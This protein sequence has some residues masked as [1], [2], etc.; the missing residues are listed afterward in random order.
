[1]LIRFR[2]IW[3]LAL[4]GVSALSLQTL[5]PQPDLA[6]EGEIPSIVYLDDLINNSGFFIRDVTVGS[7]DGDFE[8]EVEKGT[9]AFDSTGG[10]L[11]YLAIVEAQ[12]LYLPPPPKGTVIRAYDLAPKGAVFMPP[13]TLTMQY[14][15]GRDPGIG[16]YIA[17]WNGNRWVELGSAVN[18]DN[19]T[20]TAKV[21]HF[22]RFAII[23][24]TAAPTESVLPTTEL[25]VSD[26][27][28]T[29]DSPGPRDMVVVRVTVTNPETFNASGPVALALNGKLLLAQ[30]VALPGDGQQTLVF[31]L[32]AGNPGSHTVSV[33]QLSQTFV[34]GE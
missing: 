2:F 17:W 14:P 34:V 9:A 19:A 15:E 24:S 21:S 4:I 7:T 16:D 10:V 1:M 20:V 30:D 12:D 8:F 32:A 3:V 25:Q 28:I 11:S 27:K 31:T 13:L 6:A 18:T 26:L 23:Q 5:W 29:P 22:T 33:N